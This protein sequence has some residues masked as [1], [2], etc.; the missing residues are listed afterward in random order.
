MGTQGNDLLVFNGAKGILQEI[1][2]LQ[3]ELSFKRLYKNSPTCHEVLIEYTNAGFE[4]S[5]LVPNNA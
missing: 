5:A 3:S 1:R 4:L 2:G